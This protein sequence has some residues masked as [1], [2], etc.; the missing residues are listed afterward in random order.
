MMGGGGGQGSGGG[1]QGGHHGGHHREQQGV[2]GS[3]MMGGHGGHHGGSGH[4]GQHG[5][6]HTH[7][8]TMGGGDSK[9][10]QQ[11]PQQ[12]GGH[13]GGK[14]KH[15]HGLGGGDKMNS[16]DNIPGAKTGGVSID[17]SKSKTVVADPVT[18]ANRDKTTGT[19][20]Q[21]LDGGGITI[22]HGKDTKPKEDPNPTLLKNA[23]T[24]ITREYPTTGLS[25]DGKNFGI[26][27][28]K[29]NGNPSNRFVG[30][31]PFK[32]FESTSYNKIGKVG[33]GTSFLM[34]ETG[35]PPQSKHD[36][37]CCNYAIGLYGDGTLYAKEESDHTQ[38]PH[39]DDGNLVN[40]GKWSKINMG[41][42]KEGQTVGIKTVLLRG[43]K[44]SDGKQNDTRLIGKVD[45]N[46]NGKFTTF[47]DVKNPYA[48][49]RNDGK[50]FPVI[51]ETSSKL[52]SGKQSDSMAQEIRTR[53]ENMGPNTT[54]YP[55]YT[56]VHE[57]AMNKVDGN[58]DPI[59]ST[60]PKVSPSLPTVPNRPIGPTPSGGHDGAPV[61]RGAGGLTAL[62]FRD[63]LPG[64]E[65][66]GTRAELHDAQ[67]VVFGAPVKSHGRHRHGRGTHHTTDD[68][69]NSDSRMH[70]RNISST[71]Q[72]RYHPTVT[73]LLNQ[74]VR[75]M[76][77]SS[78]S[79]PSPV[80]ST[81]SSSLPSRPPGP[82]RYSRGVTD[83]YNQIQQDLNMDPEH[84]NFGDL[85]VPTTTTTTNLSHFGAVSDDDIITGLIFAIPLTIL[86]ASL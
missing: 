33:K 4:H 11:Q 42:F 17:V 74:A 85:D 67:R 68:D 27:G 69:N 46:N 5:G 79:L 36:R 37:N 50:P 57:I 65:H 26:D 18:P 43:L 52:S 20:Q 60:A 7:H 62:R 16:H 25:V 35:G 30:Y 10:P 41:A 49:S 19:Y 1:G 70:G 55:N 83:Y 71:N 75:N 66:K 38:F 32:S 56:D 14:G 15:H 77:P 54:V 59:S 78:S 58:G 72:Q 21:H 28:E 13:V 76:A 73:N 8:N 48:L 34:M 81:P 31:H 82:G 47:L 86:L 39:G 63:V 44:G 40:V 53:T 51:T 3:G 24:K 6:Q 45:L 23:S 29:N 9:Q 84:L 61:M 64:G 12:Q 2:G 80:P 22:S